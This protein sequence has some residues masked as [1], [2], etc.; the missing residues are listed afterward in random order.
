MTAG[1][2]A[3]FPIYRDLG[4]WP[5]KLKAGTKS[6][7]SGFTGHDGRDPSGADMYAWAEEEP[8]GNTAIRLPDGVIGIDV[9]NYG[10]KTGAAT[11]AEAQKRGGRLPYSPT[12]TS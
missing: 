12:S 2:A 4:W 6:P 10:N 7:P 8:G 1:Y 5:I 9:D 11:I 3:A